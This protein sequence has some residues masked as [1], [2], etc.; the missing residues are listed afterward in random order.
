MN[1]SVTSRGDKAVCRYALSVLDYSPEYRVLNDLY[2]TFQLCLSKRCRKVVT[3]EARYDW[4]GYEK[5][6]RTI[7][8]DFTS[9]HE[10]PD[11]L[12]PVHDENR[13]PVALFGWEDLDILDWS[14]HTPLQAGAWAIECEEE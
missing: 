5:F 1:F 13:A 14:V 9:S 3:L 2:S 10:L 11:S 4:S 7:V 6:G 12:G 8:F